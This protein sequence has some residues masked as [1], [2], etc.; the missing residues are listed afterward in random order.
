ML[1]MTNRIPSI[2]LA[3]SVLSASP[4]SIEAGAA[5]GWRLYRWDVIVRKFAGDY[6]LQYPRELFAHIFS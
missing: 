2:A 5:G 1:L 4:A 6:V 3:I